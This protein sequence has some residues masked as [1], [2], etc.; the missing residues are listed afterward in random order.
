[1]RVTKTFLASIVFLL[2]ASQALCALTATAESNSLQWTVTVTEPQQDA[3]LAA[4]VEHT[5]VGNVP[6]QNGNEMPV[7]CVNEDFDQME[8]GQSYNAFHFVI[9]CF[10]G[11]GPNGHCTDLTGIEIEYYDAKLHAN[12]EDVD[13]E[14]LN[15]WSGSDVAEG[16]VSSSGSEYTY[17][18]FTELSTSQANDFH[19]PT[20]FNGQLSCYFA[21]DLETDHGLTWAYS[22]TPALNS[23]E[24][25]MESG[26][27]ATTDID[28]NSGGSSGT[29]SAVGAVVGS[30][31]VASVAFTTLM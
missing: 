18:L 8:D 25:V 24:G 26:A 23:H 9:Y 6:L 4:R 27:S 3:D 16:D 5:I 28:G 15:N 2:F 17:N 12:G 14:Y 21:D 1:M 13:F 7:V 10:D 31:L 22:S 11:N 20:S 19:V 29:S 30:A